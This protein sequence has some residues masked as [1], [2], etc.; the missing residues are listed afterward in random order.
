MNISERELSSLVDSLRDLPKLFDKASKC[1]QI[2]LPIPKNEI[3]TTKSKD[4]LFT[5]LYNDIIEH[6]NRQIRLLLCFG[7]NNSCV[8]CIKNF[9]LTMTKKDASR[10]NKLLLQNSFFNLLSQK[11]NHFFQLPAFYLVHQWLKKLLLP[12]TSQLVPT[13]GTSANAMTDL[14]NFLGPRMIPI[15][16]I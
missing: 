12:W 13:T 3:E 1:L 15:T 4:N 9:E 7:N 16:W 6:S 10:S 11:I 5:H 8:F 2:P 14:D